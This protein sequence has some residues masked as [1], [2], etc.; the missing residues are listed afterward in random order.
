M[1]IFGKYEADYWRACEKF[2]VERGRF[3]SELQK[4]RFIR[5]IPSQANYF[6]CEVT[7][8]YTSHELTRILLNKFNILI[9]DCSTKSGF[10]GCNYV[11]IA[12]R[13]KNDNDM[14]IRA[15]DCIA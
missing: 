7:S 10:T 13:E 4:I 5:V 6:L 1:Q 12:I 3:L 2:I 11:R 8:K 14:L 15:L 9:K